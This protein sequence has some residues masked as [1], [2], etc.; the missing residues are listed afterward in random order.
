[1]QCD[2][3]SR[4]VRS[5]TLIG[6]LATA[7][8]SGLG[9]RA[10][11]GGHRCRRS[12]RQRES[13]Q[14]RQESSSTLGLL[15]AGAEIQSSRRARTRRRC[16]SDALSVSAGRLRPRDPAVLSGI[17]TWHI[18]PERLSWFVRDDYGRVGGLSFTNPP[19]RGT[20]IISPR[21][22]LMVLLGERNELNWAGSY[23]DVH[24]SGAGVDSNRYQGSG[25]C[26][27]GISDRRNAGPIF[28]Q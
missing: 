6:L 28:P 3:R 27:G 20:S 21:R 12:H 13:R 1:M 22:H 10:L 11:D 4:T 5:L 23:A 16:R 8:G 25:S 17:A 24:T 18:M 2:V 19:D 14:P 7:G 26:G 9:V 15:R